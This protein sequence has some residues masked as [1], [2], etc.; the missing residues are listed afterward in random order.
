MKLLCLLVTFLARHVVWICTWVLME[1][2]LHYVMIK[3]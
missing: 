2:D 1:T 3:M